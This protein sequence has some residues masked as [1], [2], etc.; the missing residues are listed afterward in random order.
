MPKSSPKKIR[1]RSIILPILFSHSFKVLVP[2]LKK[3]SQENMKSVEADLLSLLANKFQILD[4]ETLKVLQKWVS[5]IPSEIV[6]T[7]LFREIVNKA[8]SD[9]IIFEAKKKVTFIESCYSST[10]DILF[11][12]V[13]NKLLF[14]FII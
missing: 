8:L 9:L 2:L 12:M 7:S 13:I 1:N 6:Q 5:Q 14:R 11:Q 10:L 3:I 4:D